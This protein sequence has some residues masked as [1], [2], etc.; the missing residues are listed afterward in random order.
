MLD[1]DWLSGCD[2]VL[3]LSQFWSPKGL[4]GALGHLGRFP[5]LSLLCFSSIIDLVTVLDAILTDRQAG[6]KLL[7]LYENPMSNT[8]RKT[9]VL[10]KMSVVN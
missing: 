8:F 7:C 10:K 6:V 5:V 4:Q 1:T 3:T 9:P 2:H